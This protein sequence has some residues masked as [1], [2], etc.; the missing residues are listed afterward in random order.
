MS[1]LTVA[2]GTVR[3]L[4]DFA[5]SKGASREALAARSGVDP[6]SLQDQDSRIPFA[7]YT[8][9]MRASKEF[10]GD[11][12]LALHFGEL[13][14]ADMSILGLL[15]P[16]SEKVVDA[17]AQLNRYTRLAIEVE[18]ETAD[19]YRFEPGGGGIWLIDTR[20]NPNDF[21]DLTESSF[22]RIARG[23]AFIVAGSPAFAD[24][25][26]FKTVHVT[27]ADPGYRA[28]YDRIF[29]APVVFE[30]DRNAILFDEACL[31]CRVPAQPRYA[32]DVL[33]ER[34]ETLLADLDRS[35]TMRGRVE[36]LLLPMLRKGEIGMDAIAG[37]MGMSR[38]TLSRRLKAEGAT[39]DKI[40]D[41]LRCRMALHYLNAKRSMN[42]TAYLVGFSEPAAFSRAFKRWTGSS[43]R[44]T[45]T[46]SVRG[47][48]NG[49]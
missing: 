15:G 3:A 12:A 32:L 35:K 22:A 8:A 2:A 46:R 49:A 34:A 27:H 45:Q 44:T 5:A 39:F 37:R 7:R 38:W 28:E 25:G 19:R 48:Q 40:L 41:E 4:M 17:L 9:L 43:P 11:P 24:R 33:T 13:D 18:T 36:S 42:E 30:S 31:A 21:P 20:L 23:F 29:R 26:P 1:D 10:C 47:V 6:R 14:L 16:A